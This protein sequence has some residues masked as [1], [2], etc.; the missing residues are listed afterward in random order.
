[1]GTSRHRRRTICVVT[2]SRADYGHITSL[3]E[4]VREDADLKLQLV[5]TGSHLEPQFGLTWREIER[6]GFTIDRKVKILRDDNTDVGVTKAFGFGCQKFADVFSELKPDIVVLLGDRYEIFAACVAA[7]FQRI[8]IAHIHGGETTEGAF[9]EGIRHS[10]SKM[11]TV[12]FASADAYAK[13]IVQLGE[14][15]RRV[16]PFGAPGLDNI[17]RADLLDRAALAAELGL[18]LTAPVGMVT[19]HP[20]T[21]EN[22]DAAGQVKELLTALERSQLTL[23]F[24][25]ANADPQGMK[26]NAALKKFCAAHPQRAK[27]FD[28]LGQRRYYSFLKIADVM[29]GNSSSGLLEAPVFRLPVVNIGDRQRSRIRGTNV[30]DVECR[31]AA[32]T[33][34]IRKALS[35]AF[36]RSLKR[37]AN[38]YDRAGGRVGQRIKDQLKRL[39]LTD[40]VLKKKFF[41]MPVPSGRNGRS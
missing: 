41:D 27:L 3:L 12:H 25:K 35:P 23:I 11:S 14:S 4:A 29:I 40:D 22:A 38:P 1:M 6:D 15:P 39:P 24:T 36:R 26:I 37:Q 10:I 8:P 21:L 30:I 33:T 19:Y 28:N 17:R 16:F 9:D 34:G 5:A 13:R 18:E 2:G 31:A 7:Y 20:V 32:I